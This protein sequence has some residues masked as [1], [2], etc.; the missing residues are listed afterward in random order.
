MPVADWLRKISP[1]GDEPYA[2]VRWTGPKSYT[3]VTAG[4]PP[5]GGDQVNASQC[6]VNMIVLVLGDSSYT[7]RFQIV[8]IR[9]SD[10]IWALKWISMVT[11]TVGGQSQVAGT[12]AIAAT[13]LTGESVKLQI[14]C[15]TG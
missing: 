15:V 2:R 9:V 11:A 5:T 10:K 8:P 4:A 3:Q 13:D 6:G 1:P 12:E 14:N 7:G